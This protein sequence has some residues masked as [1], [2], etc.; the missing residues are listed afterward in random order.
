MPSPGLKDAMTVL[1]EERLREILLDATTRRKLMAP[2]ALKA[3]DVAEMARELLAIRSL[4]TAS[5]LREAVQNLVKAV[6]VYQATLLIYA[7]AI[8][9]TGNM[10]QI[11]ELTNF[12]H[13]DSTLCT[14]LSHPALAAFAQEENT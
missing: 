10:A 12:V 1:P 2:V 14:A 11:A 13:A 8:K 6:H 5:P 7:T 3:D 9:K 4:P